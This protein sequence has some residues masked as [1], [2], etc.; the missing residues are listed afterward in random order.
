MLARRLQLTPVSF[1]HCVPPLEPSN[2][3]ATIVFGAQYMPN[4]AIKA[5][6]R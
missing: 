3:L 5:R 1:A 6:K 4:V 2:Y